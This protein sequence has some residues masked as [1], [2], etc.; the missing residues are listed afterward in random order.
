MYLGALERVLAVEEPVQYPVVVFRA[1]TR[2]C[3]LPSIH[4]QETMRV[5]PTQLLAAAP[6]FVI[7]VALIRGMAVPVVDAGALLGETDEPSATRF[8]SLRIGDRSIA[9]A[10]EAVLGVQELASSELQQLPPLLRDTSSEVMSALGTLDA[11]L[12]SVLKLARTLTE[13]ILHALD[14]SVSTA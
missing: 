13:P 9:L 11:E 4:V 6:D 7:G 14:L 1:R 12:L 2:L 3:A 10:V 5:L 8:I